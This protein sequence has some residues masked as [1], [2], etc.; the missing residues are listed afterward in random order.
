SFRGRLGESA[1]VLG[2]CLKFD[3][4]FD[5]L[6][7]RLGV[8]VFLRTTE[9]Q[10]NNQYQAMM[11]RFQALSTRASQAGSFIRPEIMSIPAAKIKKFMAAKELEPYRLQ[12]QRLLRFKPHTLSA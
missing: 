3:R 8:Y 2:E 6:A 7:E 12:M 5:R 9:V 1:A 4:E 11:G 10:A